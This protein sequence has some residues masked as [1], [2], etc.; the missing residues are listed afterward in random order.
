MHIR[1]NIFLTPLTLLML[2]PLLSGCR[3]A[4][5]HGYAGSHDDTLAYYVNKIQDC[6]AVQ[7]YDGALSISNRLKDLGSGTENSLYV[8]YAE[9]YKA[10]CF[11]TTN[12]VDSMYFYFE[13]N[14]PEAL[15]EKDWWAVATLYNAMGGNA[16]FGEG[17]YSKGIGYLTEGVQ[18][19]RE[20]QD[21]SR[22]MLL[23]TNL[24][25]LYYAIND[26]TGLRYALD[27]YRMGLDRKYDYNIF[28]GALITAYMYWMLHDAPEA[29]SYARKALPYV[30]K[31]DLARETWSLYADIL[32]NN[33]GNDS[34]VIYYEKAFREMQGPGLFSVSGLFIGYSQY[35]KENGQYDKAIDVLL[36]GLRTTDT[37]RSPMMRPQM[38]L[39]LSEIYEKMSEY[40]T[41]LDYYKKYNEEGNRL[42]SLETE[43]EINAVRMEYEK[44]RH[45]VELLGWRNRYNTA[46]MACALAICVLA[47]LYVLYH[48]KKKNYHQLLKQH[49]AILEKQ[50][51]GPARSAAVSM[52][53]DRMKE[54]F[55]RLESLMRGQKLYRQGDLSRDKVA[56]MLSTNRTYL[57]AVIKSFTGMSFNYYVNSFRIN[58]AVMILSD[59]GNDTP[60]KAV[61]ASLG[62]NNLTTFY[63]LF[64][65]AK[66]MPPSRYRD[67]VLQNANL[68]DCKK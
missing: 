15:A 40:G 23:E 10:Q 38:F 46:V 47:G 25:M 26:S 45:E 31:Y 66:G 20:I 2:L 53:E 52:P 9:I 67:T 56:Q 61:A 43:R 18:Y 19:A 30:E 12:V 36:R 49:Q 13:K 60:I 5:I 50:D 1:I 7:D 16:A 11:M 35:L 57:C 29:I 42:L 28:L 58:E 8:L 41:A 59:P 54:M 64:E 32:R 44:K 24:A 48:N 51:A 33:G 62:Y 17:N 37:L 14:L 68:A 65:A 55:D 22:L 34:A 4:D 39:I 3:H 63:R 6:F 27:V 21:T